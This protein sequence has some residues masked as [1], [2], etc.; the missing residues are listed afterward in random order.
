MLQ[1]SVGKFLD[2]WK[3]GMFRGGETYPRLPWTPNGFEGNLDLKNLPKRPSQQVFGRLYRV[4]RISDKK[5]GE[6]NVSDIPANN[7]VGP[8]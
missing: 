2:C 5:T 6:S 1:G 7:K 3:F 4:R 8:C